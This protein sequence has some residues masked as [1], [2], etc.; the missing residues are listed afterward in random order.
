M[1]GKLFG[2]G[3]GPGDPE[4]LT[5]KAVRVMCSCAY[6]AVPQ[7]GKGRQIA[8]EICRQ[9][10]E[11]KIVL[12][13][14]IP[15]TYNESALQDSYRENAEKI[16]AILNIGEDVAFLTI[17][18][19]SIYSTYIYI[20][21]VISKMGFETEMIP[22]V[23]SFCAAAAD[24]NIPLCEKD[25][26]LYIIPA[27]YLKDNIASLSGNVIYMKLGKK[28]K[29]FLES[30]K[31]EG[32]LQKSILIENASMQDQRVIANLNTMQEDTGYLSMV[33]YKEDI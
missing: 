13:L 19:P 18:D 21:R 1:K 29:P 7:S 4:L 24:A 20:E 32:K 14:S 28:L 27:S 33:I 23:P 2:V 22:G 6:I 3:V 11:D 12:D 30:L 26:P 31:K 25:Q 16:T 15:M 5:L 10:L 17:G 9:Y 8:L